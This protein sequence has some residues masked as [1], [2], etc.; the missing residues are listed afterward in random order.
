MK[1]EFGY[2]YIGVDIKSWELESLLLPK[3]DS[4]VTKMFIEFLR[5][6][7]KDGDLVIIWDGAGYHR[8]EQVK[9]I[10]KVRF[11]TIPAHSAELNPVERLIEELR[12]AIANEVFNNLEEI[13]TVLIKEL[14]EYMNNTE[15]VESVCGFPWIK[16]QLGDTHLTS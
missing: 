8:S 16:K 13:E 6:R 9:G 15:K 4:L 1:Y 12:K 10:E 5:E 7:S 3:T 2:I 14:K 11:V